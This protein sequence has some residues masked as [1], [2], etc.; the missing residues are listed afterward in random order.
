MASYYYG[1]GLTWAGYL[2]ADSFVRD[3]TGQIRKSGEATRHE[4]SAQTREMVASNELLSQEFGRGFD[5]V[6]GTLEMGFD[7]LE[8][9]LGD[10]E[11]SIESLHSDFNYNMGLVLD[12]LQI[13]NQ[14]TFGILERLDAIHKTLEHPELTKAREFYDRGCERLSKGLLDKALEAFLN[15][16][17]KN[18]TDFFIQFQIGKLYLYGMD[19][20]DNVID[21]PKA[22]KH[23]RDAARYGKA[24]IAAMPE[25]KRWAGEALL[26]TS[27]A[28]YAQANDQQINGD[29]AGAKEFISKAFQLAQQ[30]CEIYPSLSESQYHLAKYAALLGDLEISV[31]SL[32]KAVTSDVNYCLKTEFDR[33]FDK[34]RPQVFDLFE[35]LRVKMSEKARS[36]LRECK[37]N[38]IINM[39]YLTDE[40]KKC[41]EKI[42]NFLLN[43][44]IEI[45]KDTIFDMHGALQTID[46]IDSTF[47]NIYNQF[48]EKYSL[49]FTYFEHFDYVKIDSNS[50]LIA[51]FYAGRVEI[52]QINTGKK[53]YELSGHPLSLSPDWKL[54]ATTDSDEYIKI[55]QVSNG[56]ILHTLPAG[57]YRR[58]NRYAEFSPDGKLV[59]TCGDSSED[60]ENENVRLWRVSDGTLLY[61]LS[62][63]YARFSPKG[64]FI[65]T[66]DGKTTKLYQVSDGKLL[67]TLLGHIYNIFF[68]PNEEFVCTNEGNVKLWRMTNEGLKLLYTLSGSIYSIELFSPDGEIIATSDSRS[69]KLWRVSDGT[70]LHTLDG[71][72]GNFSRSGELIATSDSRSIKLWRVSDG[73]FLHTFFT[74]NFHGDLSFSPD[75]T[76]IVSPHDKNIDFCQ[77]NGGK[78]INYSPYNFTLLSQN[79]NYFITSDKIG[80]ST[81]ETK[82]VKVWGRQVISKKEFDQQ[83]RL[84]EIEKAE[85]EKRDR[86]RQNLEGQQKQNAQEYIRRVDGLCSICGAKLSFWDKL[87]GRTTCSKHSS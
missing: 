62:G 4:I 22:E 24:E 8:S 71:D 17:E 59:S 29:S 28:C 16:E 13:Q 56:K 38:Y 65:R 66:T 11:A 3:V 1:S 60:H 23:L 50:E 86:E 63:D 43:A 82:V 58:L 39:V 19:E 79:G 75:G 84:E 68:S 67:H 46:Q 27:I 57:Y 44:D 6:N 25:F 32:E 26:H 5:A 52:R 83:K 20:D 78:I 15:A 10:V 18:D 49:D 21:L 51:I 69:I 85:T 35:R 36:R 40:A 12:Q 81:R 80:T 48:I 47:F 76:Q 30:A 45:S 2:Q 55:L 31:Q 34:M 42:N 64:R 41:E 37:Q 87:R 61:T 33:D 53:L 70:L 14:L 73:T 9:A 54:I 74:R 77:I 72:F 7:R